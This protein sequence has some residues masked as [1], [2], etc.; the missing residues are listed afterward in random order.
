MHLLG[1]GDDTKLTVNRDSS[2]SRGSISGDRGVVIGLPNRGGLRR[3]PPQLPR[4]LIVLGS[5]KP[6][7]PSRP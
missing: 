3:V 2:Y 6:D 4:G 5:C 1:P 7:G